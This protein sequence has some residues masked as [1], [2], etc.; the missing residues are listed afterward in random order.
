MASR[1][2][3][4]RSK[5]RRRKSPS[6]LAESGM[7][8]LF[9]G[10][11]REDLVA[12]VEEVAQRVEDLG[13][14]DAQR[15]GD[16]QDRFALPV[17]RDHVTDRHP[18]PVDHGFA[19]AD[20][21]D[22]DDVGVTRLDGLGPGLASGG[23]SPSTASVPDAWRPDQ[24]GTPATDPEMARPRQPDGAFQDSHRRPAHSACRFSYSF[25]SASLS[26]CRTRSR[27]SPRRSPLRE[28]G[29]AAG[30][31]PATLRECSSPKAV[32]DLRRESK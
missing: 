32:P 21:F 5:Y 27:V 26:I 12:V 14:G 19:A 10:D 31:A 18:Q 30:S 8:L 9:L 13:L 2:M 3:M 22:S 23:N 17:Q 7:G 4:W 6:G 28:P 16:L 24:A 25:D 1:V 15:L 29:A 20:P 11:Q